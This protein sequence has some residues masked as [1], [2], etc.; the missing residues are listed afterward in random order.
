MSTT[1]SASLNLRR[2][3]LA[4]IADLAADRKLRPCFKAAHRQLHVFFWELTQ[5]ERTLPFVEDLMFD[6]NGSYPQ[7]EQ[8]DDFLQ[9]LQLSGILSRPNPT[10]RYN[11][12]A[13][14]S[15]PSGDEFKDQLTAEQRAAYAEVLSAFKAQL[16]VPASE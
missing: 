11:D 5:S 6:T 4:L 7:S 3:L 13:I 12:I 1:A 14:T 15:S 10:Y 2:F 16:G 9:E 8:I